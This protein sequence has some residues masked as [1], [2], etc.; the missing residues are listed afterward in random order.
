MRTQNR[1]GFV[2]PA[3]YAGILRIATTLSARLKGG[4]YT[5]QNRVLTQALKAVHAQ[6]WLSDLKVGPPKDTQNFDFAKQI[7]SR[8]RLTAGA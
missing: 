4:R 3:F 8:R 1:H 2:A 6:L 7:E 5:K